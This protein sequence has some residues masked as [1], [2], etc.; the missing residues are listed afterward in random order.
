MNCLDCLADDEL[1][2]PAVAV[3][4]ECGA[5]VCARHARVSVRRLHVDAVM[6]RRQEVDPPGRLVRCLTCHDAQAAHPGAS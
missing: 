4:H 2:A 1:A 5:A 6:Y 3:C